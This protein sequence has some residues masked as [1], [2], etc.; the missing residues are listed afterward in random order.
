MQKDLIEAIKEGLRVFLM[1]AIPLVIVELGEGGLFDYRAVII[2]GVIAL[3][4]FI[5]SFLHETAMST[6]KANRNEG[7]L[8]TKGITG[9]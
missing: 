1:A 9:F 7:I 5:D 6:P 2:A 8:G 3:L 4:R